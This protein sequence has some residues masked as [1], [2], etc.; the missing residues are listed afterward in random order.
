MARLLLLIPSTSYRVRDFIRAAHRLGI[1]ITVGSNERQVLESISEGQTVT[2]NFSDIK[3]ATRD[4]IAFHKN[5][6]VTSIIAVDD[7]TGII[8][9]KASEALG[10]MHNSPE[11]VQTAGNKLLLR[12]KLSEI[13]VP[14]PK[15]KRLALSDNPNLIA[16]EIDYP[17]VLKPLNLSASQGVIRANDT[18]EFLT[19]FNRI[20]TLLLSMLE[21]HQKNVLPEII[22]EDFVEGEEV[23]VE[24]LMVDGKLTVLTMFDKPDPLEG[25]YFEET[26]YITPSRK[27]AKVIQSIKNLIE[28][29]ANS[30]GLVHG[31]I[32]AEIRVQPSGQ[33]TNNTGPWIIE[34]AARSIGGL[35]SRSLRFD[36]KLTLEDIIIRHALGE[37]VLPEREKQASGVMMIPIPR[38]GTL[39]RID[40]ML[41]AQAINGVTE[42]TITIPV[43]GEVIPLPEGNKYLGFIFAKSTTPEK[44]EKVL[45]TAHS[46]LNFSID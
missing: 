20:K 39:K 9:A 18:K 24:G 19:A 46:K 14:S 27:P 25:P 1:D 28:Q 35:C 2:I 23:A 36:D 29:A 45:R 13:D 42:I 4:I 15:F 17:C 40:G 33:N 12:K 43:G 37:P 41:E 30:I 44:T 31:P 22:I 10:L 11:T 26:I 34:I 38:A 3:I 6:P 32:H 8:A 5:F 7:T 21:S 16:H